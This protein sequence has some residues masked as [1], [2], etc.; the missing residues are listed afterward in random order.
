M[1][2][3]KIIDVS[4]A[5]CYD[6][7]TNLIENE[8]KGFQGG[9]IVVHCPSGLE[10]ELKEYIRE[11]KHEIVSQTDEEKGKRFKI[12]L[13]RKSG[14]PGAGKGENC[15]ICGGSLNY[16]DEPIG[17]ECFYC[18]KEE[19]TRITC[20]EGHFVCDECHGKGAYEAIKEIALSSDSREPLSLAEDMM[21]HPSV[22]MLGCENA[23]IVPASLMTAL[24]NNGVEIEDKDLVE[25]MDRTRE[26]S[27]PPYCA[28]TGACGVALGVG[29]TISVL[30]NA[31]CP[32]D[33]PSAITMHSLARVLGAMANDVGP[34]CCKS[35]V[36]TAIGVAHNLLKEYLEIYIPVRRDI[37][38]CV[39]SDRHP[40]ECRKSKC[41]YYP[42]S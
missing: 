19:R 28:L 39:F 41:L 25:A 4:E 37:I 11:E 5:C 9:T 10:D 18:N 16:L 8:L 30:V 35:F 6:T 1:K 24:R 42:R 26:Q 32:K 38:S 34:M 7:L 23:L 17:A 13:T 3:E 31:Q 33:R 22:P 2:E 36:R 29:A 12:N 14:L 15:V 21:S 27:K 40:H 20:P